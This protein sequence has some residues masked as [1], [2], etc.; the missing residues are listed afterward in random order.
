MAASGVEM[1]VVKPTD[2]S[3]TAALR[4]ITSLRPLVKNQLL[5]RLVTH[6]MLGND[7]I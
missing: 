2:S 7:E 3:S 6:K 1:N 5:H 4:G